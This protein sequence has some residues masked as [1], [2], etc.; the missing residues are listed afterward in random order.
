[1]NILCVRMRNNCKDEVLR[2]DYWDIPELLSQDK[3]EYEAMIEG[4]GWRPPDS[5][6]IFEVWTE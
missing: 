3:A 4:K 5:P 1:M 2:I 6:L